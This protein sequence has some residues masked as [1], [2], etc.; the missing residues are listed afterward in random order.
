MIEQKRASLT[1]KKKR[2]SFLFSTKFSATKLSPTI[3][4][5][6]IPQK[7]QC[8]TREKVVEATNNSTDQ[9][10]IQKLKRVLLDL[11]K[12]KFRLKKQELRE[13]SFERIQSVDSKLKTIKKELKQN[14]KKLEK[15][16]FENHKMEML[17]NVTLNSEY[18]EKMKKMKI[19]K[20]KEITNL[21]E[22]IES[23]KYIQSG[24]KIELRIVQK[25]K[26]LKKFTLQTNSLLN[27]L[28][29]SKMDLEKVNL[30]L[31]EYLEGNNQNKAGYE[32]ML[33]ENKMLNTF[34]EQYK[35]IKRRKKKISFDLHNIKDVKSNFLKVKQRLKDINRD[36]KSRKLD[37]NILKSKI[38]KLKILLQANSELVQSSKKNLQL[39]LFSNDSNSV[40]SQSDRETDFSETQNSDI[41]FDEKENGNQKDSSNENENEN[42]NENKT[43]KDLVR[44]RE[45]VNKT[46]ERETD[47]EQTNLIEK[48]ITKI[49]FKSLEELLA[50]EI[51]V[52]YFKEFLCQQLNQENIMFFLEVKS[53]KQNCNSERQLVKTSK[54][55]FK[56]FIE[57]GSIFEIN[58]ISE[59]RKKLISQFNEKSYSIMMFDEAHKA[60]IDHMNLNSWQ[61][62]QESILYKKLINKLERDPNFAFRPNLKRLKL[63]HQKNQTEYLN[64]EYQANLEKFVS[65]EI[66][67]KLMV[68][69]INLLDANYAVSRE[70]INMKTISKSIPFRRFVQHTSSLQAIDLELMT[71]QE[72]TCFFLN[73]YN[74]LSLHSLIVNGVPGDRGAFKKILKK[75]AYLIGKYKFSLLDI[76]H[77]IL[78]GNLTSKH[79]DYFKMDDPRAKYTLKRVD[80]RFH[81][82][83][84]NHS[85]LTLI[86]VYR[87]KQL[88]PTLDKITYQVISSFFTAQ[89]NTIFLPK[90]FEKFHKDFGGEE[91]I[92]TWIS[93]FLKLNHTQFLELKSHQIKFLHCD[94]FKPMIWI[95][96]KRTLSRKF[97]YGQII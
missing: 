18:S 55:I 41:Y 31:S 91:E 80:G 73:L 93:M 51:A 14:K 47:N 42:E 94:Q 76:Y 37:N 13:K 5:K 78:R 49:E 17:K 66:S 11:K 40:I 12:K 68:N 85:L 21:E 58:I 43:K 23:I 19:L 35:A 95:D 86:K 34:S 88:N 24:E 36:L 52:Q 2:M 83:I 65:Y 28:N 1:L 33:I 53:F 16:K 63:V 84:I 3:T 75:S 72:R 64:V 29:V 15:L 54:H 89:D 61:S 79:N 26:K 81:F 39:D 44:K 7:P 30:K 48:T 97:L 32:L 20:E 69:L 56:T 70:S 27:D 6:F 4:R 50:V 25:T 62:F 67:E 22:K 90:L 10:E 87:L 82:S 71:F 74:V 92:V 8:K 45:T 60:V 96:L 77:G 38:Q 9:K 46:K 57:P 59:M